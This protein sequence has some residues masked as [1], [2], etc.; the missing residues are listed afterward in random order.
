MS[1]RHTA[2]RA[3]TNLFSGLFGALLLV[4]CGSNSNNSSSFLVQSAALRTSAANEPVVTGRWMVFFAEE[5]PGT[6]TGSQNLNTDGDDSDQV[7]V[8]VDLSSAVNYPL[9]V[10]VRSVAGV[11]ENAIQIVGDQ[12]YLVVDE[13]QDGIDWDGNPGSDDLVLLHWRL[14]S[15]EV[16]NG[17]GFMNAEG[18]SF[19]DLLDVAAL[20][21]P[22]IAAGNRLIYSSPT[23]PVNPGETS[24]VA[25]EAAAPLTGV[26]LDS[27][28]AV[29]LQ[30]KILAVDPTGILLL[31][32][33][34]GT[35]VEDYNGDT[36]MD[37][38]R[39]LAFY[40]LRD[41]ATALVRNVG[42]ALPEGDGIWNASLSNEDVLLSFL[43]S[44]DGQNATNLNDPALFPTLTQCAMADAD[45]TDNVLA[46][47]YVEDF[48]LGNSGVRN[49]GLVGRD[50]LMVAAGND[51]ILN[52]DGF[53][54][55]L[56]DESAANCDLNDDGDS[57]DT[58]LRW[59]AAP[60]DPMLA[61]EPVVDEALLL[62]S[63]IAL[64][65]ESKG[66]AVLDG[67][68]V[69]IVDEAAE[70]DDIDG[71]GNPLDGMMMPITHQLV[72]WLDPR[73]GA[74]ASWTFA[75]DPGLGQI[76]VGAG[77]MAKESREGRL[78]FAFQEELAGISLNSS[79]DS[80]SMADGDTDDEL[81]SWMRFSSGRMIFP[82]VGFA[83][84][85]SNPGIVIEGVHAFFRVSEMMED[86]DYNQDGDK[87]DA[88]LARN[89]L[90][91]CAPTLMSTANSVDGLVIFT[92]GLQ[93]GAFFAS[94]VMDGKDINGDGMVGDLVVR[95]F[96]F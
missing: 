87:A 74:A 27:D 31:T 28:A 35:F 94:E 9:G 26:A 1:A 20:P 91:T 67:N 43:V 39:V 44:E 73:M 70:N 34:E 38:E 15:N 61:I 23:P 88:I 92:D 81:A 63:A 84:E 89:P 86:V 57:L 96:R 78:A 79:C 49:T 13:A 59:T 16:P 85:P 83:L 21:R 62:A 56:S 36:D 93:G 52:S 33:D 47:I 30:P 22:A 55:V 32:L 42:Q 77:W 2:S 8:A 76:Y 51:R 17:A 58:V 40:D 54:A 75:H 3:A 60:A 45:A 7:A 50:P 25:L 19:V 24:L 69:L 29:P 95:Y 10:A 46:Y 14:G 80:L 82:G 64:P 12:I 18:V 53:I 65:G 41:P 66:V 5:N 90:F 68:W 11:V 72:G 4:A 48:V 71:D 6:G 37:D